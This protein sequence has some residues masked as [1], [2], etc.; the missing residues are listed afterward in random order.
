[1]PPKKNFILDITAETIMKAHPEL[2]SSKIGNELKSFVDSNRDL[3]RLRGEIVRLRDLILGEGFMENLTEEKIREY[4]IN[5]LYII[6]LGLSGKEA[7]EY[8]NLLQ[9]ALGKKDYSDYKSGLFGTSLERRIEEATLFNDA[10]ERIEEYFAH[11]M[12]PITQKGKNGKYYVEGTDSLEEKKF[13]ICYKLYDYAEKYEETLSAIE[14]KEE[15]FKVKNAQMDENSAYFPYPSDRNDAESTWEEYKRVIVAKDLADKFKVKSL[16]SFFRPA[17]VIKAEV[18]ANIKEAKELRE[19]IK[20]NNSHG[21]IFKFFFGW[22]I[23]L[24]NK[25]ID[26]KL[27]VLRTKVYNGRAFDNYMNCSTSFFEEGVEDLFIAEEN[28]KLIFADENN[29]KRLENKK[30]STAINYLKNY[31]ESFIQ[32]NEYI[33]QINELQDASQELDNSI[34]ALI[35]V[36]NIIEKAEKDEE[37]ATFNK[38]LTATDEEIKARAEQ[39]DHIYTQKSNVK[40]PVDTPFAEDYYRLKRALQLEEYKSVQNFMKESANMP[41]NER[42]EKAIEICQKIA[43]DICIYEQNGIFEMDKVGKT[44]QYDEE[45]KVIK[46]E[47]EISDN[48]KKEKKAIDDEKTAL[49]SSTKETIKNLLVNVGVE[50]KEA[51]NLAGKYVNTRVLSNTLWMS[52]NCNCFDEAKTALDDAIEKK[53]E[54]GNKIAEQQ[55]ELNQF[56]N[57]NVS[58]QDKILKNVEKMVTD[59]VNKDLKEVSTAHTRQVSEAEDKR[60]DEME[61][62]MENDDYEEPQRDDDVISIDIADL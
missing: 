53:A 31:D 8:D 24:Q 5:D 2:P 43:N 12:T 54:I 11:F 56:L 40:Y 60:W 42:K 51:K 33:D 9:K 14:K 49:L 3:E 1:M 18:D 13:S 38:D 41:E 17:D 29:K 6:G 57:A 50:E 55:K 39:V 32:A 37:I 22:Y 44:I 4:N 10:K 62:A 47:K 26:N 46:D 16:E 61:Q 36:D 59:S 21:R 35:G 58:T 7:E 20:A 23:N 15:E 52:N 45:D 27:A 28:T 30:I 25:N 48:V 34:N 19:A